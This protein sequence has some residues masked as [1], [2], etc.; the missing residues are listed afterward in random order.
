MRLSRL[1]SRA[2]SL[3]LAFV[4]ALPAS[5]VLAATALADGSGPPFPR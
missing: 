1:S 4:L 5:L 2:R 3:F